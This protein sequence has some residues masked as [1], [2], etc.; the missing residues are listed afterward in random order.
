MS[1]R[2]DWGLFDKAG[3]PIA[4]GDEHWKWVCPKGGWIDNIY[5]HPM[6][7]ELINEGFVWVPECQ[8]KSVGIKLDR[9]TVCQVEF[10]Y[11]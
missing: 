2:T 7:G 8:F 5:E 10:R 11:P 3:M 1:T 9:C 6:S 4:V